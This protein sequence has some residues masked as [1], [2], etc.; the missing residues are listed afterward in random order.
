MPS[1]PLFEELSRELGVLKFH[2]ADR[3]LI[4]REFAIAAVTA[5]GVD[6]DV[7]LNAPSHLILAE[8]FEI[9]GELRGVRALRDGDL[10][11]AV[12]LLIAVLREFTAPRH[13]LID[14]PEASP[15]TGP[16]LARSKAGAV[17]MLSDLTDSGPETLGPGSKEHKSVFENLHRGLGFGE[18]PRGLTKPELAGHMVERLGG[19]WDHTCWSTGSTVTLTG[20]NRLLTLASANIARIRRA[21]HPA[22]EAEMLI[23]HLAREITAAGPVWEGRR[24]VERMARAGFRHARQTEWPG[25]FFEFLALDPLIAEFGGGPHRIGSVEFDYR[26][27]YTWDLKTHAS[28]GTQVILNDQRAIDT[29]IAR[30]GGIGFIILHGKAGFEGEQEFWQW[31]NEFRKG[32]ALTAQE[33]RRPDSRVLKTSFRPTHLE[34]LWLD[35]G[36]LESDAVG[37]FRQGRQADGSPRRP[38]YELDLGSATELRLAYL[39]L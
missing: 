14:V 13:T 33:L 16:V 8:I 32:R 39:P 1:T 3:G 21:P 30:F 37:V 25:W 12:H 9:A 19:T 27:A 4:P 2:V 38:K 22:R 34:A 11:R 6:A 29:A 31:H 20:L 18:P 26:H 17:Q 24:M 35:G 5:M 28:A 10:E 23:R 36:A 7:N 15:A